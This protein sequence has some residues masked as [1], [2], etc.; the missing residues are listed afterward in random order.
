[1]YLEE[2]LLEPHTFCINEIGISNNACVFT[3]ISHHKLTDTSKATDSDIFAWYETA[4]YQLLKR[5]TMT[6][7]DSL[8]FRNCVVAMSYWIEN[9]R[10][11]S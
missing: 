9:C 2:I 8:S 4:E 10:V 11:R 3:S 1:M 7:L 6:R 5:T